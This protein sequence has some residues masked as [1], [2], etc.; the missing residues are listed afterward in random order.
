MS[1]AP[2]VSVR[3]ATT[4]DV[5]TIIHLIRELAIYEKEP[6]AAKATPDLIRE[7]VFEKEYAHC[8][9][10]EKEGEDGSGGKKKEPVGL[11]LVSG[12]S[13]G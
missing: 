12:G 2:T 8:L 11:A 13:D 9:I 4:D 10:A 3:P 5:P 6:E 7:N 1:S